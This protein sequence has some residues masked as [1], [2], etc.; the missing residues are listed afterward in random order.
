MNFKRVSTSA[1]FLSYTLSARDFNNAGY[2]V[3]KCINTDGT[4]IFT[5]DTSRIIN[6][7]A[8]FYYLFFKWP[9]VIT[10]DFNGW[11]LF[12]KSRFNMFDVRNDALCFIRD[13]IQTIK[14]NI[15]KYIYIYR[16]WLCDVNFQLFFFIYLK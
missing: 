13:R 14:L 8:L 11:L 16:S 5:K 7:H 9:V 6:E 12:G 10:F 2:S 4:S 1:P 15:F 3:W